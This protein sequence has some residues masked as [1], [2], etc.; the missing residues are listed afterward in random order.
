VPV[1]VLILSA[2][3]GEGHDRP[4]LWLAEQI[5]SERPDAVVQIEDSL[6]VMGRVVSVLSEGAPRV[7]FYRLRW[8]WDFGFWLFTGP[9]AGRALGQRALARLG[10]PGLLRLV[11]HARPDVVVSVF[12]QATEVLVRLRRTQRLELPVFAAITDVAALD[13]WACPGA[14]A[15]L[16]TQPEAIEEVRRIA[17]AGADVQTVTGFTDP[18]FYAPRPRAD[19]RRALGLPEEGT[20]VLVSGG[21]WGVGDVAGAAAESLAIASASIVCLTGRNDDLR[22]ALARR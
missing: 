17:G 14:D 8:L 16:V 4:A 7:I 15:Y 12:P 11:E 6:R 22:G 10:A 5:R 19:A 2:S 1:R 13:Y 3:V 18:A 21:G 9:T 20:I